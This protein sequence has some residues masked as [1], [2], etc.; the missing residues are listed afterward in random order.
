MEEA[1]ESLK[2]CPCQSGEWEMS[3]EKPEPNGRLSSASRVDWRATAS[4]PRAQPRGR[5]WGRSRTSP[6]ASSTSSSPC[7]ATMSG[8]IMGTGTGNCLNRRLKSLNILKASSPPVDLQ[9]Y[10]QSAPW[11]D[12]PD[13]P[14]CWIC[15]S[16]RA[17]P[18]WTGDYQV[19]VKTLIMFSL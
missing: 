6:P 17:H 11:M 13:S 5:T 2:T 14:G 4:G 10:P 16:H 1:L 19:V 8:S 12:R 3:V 9:T 18:H 7:S 15:S